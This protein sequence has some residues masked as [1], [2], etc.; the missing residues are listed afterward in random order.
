MNSYSI[1]LQ[2][3]RNLLQKMDR[4]I[5]T[6]GIQFATRRLLRTLGTEVFIKTNKEIKKVLKSKPVLVVANHPAKTDV[7]A[8]LASLPK[9]KEV[10]LIIDSTCLNF[11]DNWKKHLI[12][13]Y[14]NHHLIMKKNWKF[15][16]YKWAFGVR[17]NSEKIEHKKNIRSIEKAS[18]YVDK[19][20]L[21]ILFPGGGSIDDRWLS[22]VGYL[23]KDVKNKNKTFVVKAY[24]EGTSNRDYLR[25]VP[26]VGKLLSGFK[27]TFSDPILLK[28]FEDENAKLIALSM[29]KNYNDWTNTLEKREIKTGFNIPQVSLRGYLLLRTVFLW[30]ISK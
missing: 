24:I 8:L 3:L 11:G 6:D 10:K 21:I 4:Q 5:E 18:R 14:I 23:V 29:E 20:N 26:F 15:G 28:E 16:V 9:R 22:G 13:V 12:P 19:G 25:L 17:A 1:P 27:I 2:I 30:F 7:P